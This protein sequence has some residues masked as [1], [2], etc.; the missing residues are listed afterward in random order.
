MTYYQAKS[1]TFGRTFI[2]TV[3]AALKTVP[4]AALLV[5]GKLRLSQDPSFNPQPSSLIADLTPAEADYSG[6]VAGGV[7]VVLTAPVNLS[8]VA[9]GVLFTALYLAAAA[10]PFVANNV[11][12]WWIDDGTNYVAGE[13]FQNNGVASF[14][15]PGAFLNLTAVLPQQLIQGTS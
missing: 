9:D 14:S 11:T 3:L 15:A 8:T 4:G 12:G 1:V 2:N 5:A 7:A 10:T 13:R 6:Y